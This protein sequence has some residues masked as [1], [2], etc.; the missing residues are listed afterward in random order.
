MITAAVLAL[1]V[2]AGRAR[3]ACAEYCP[4]AFEGTSFCLANGELYANLCAASCFRP[5]TAVEF[6]CP[7]AHGLTASACSNRCHRSVLAKL[8]AVFWHAKCYCPRVYAPVCGA[9]DQTYFNDCFRSC[10]GAD[11]ARNGSCTAPAT[12]PALDAQFAPVCGHNGLTYA[13]T[14]LATRAGSSVARSGVCAV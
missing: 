6:E 11:F 3:F 12:E 5:E 4:K 1:L 9:N 2:S 13:S 7:F 8:A 10:N 14:A